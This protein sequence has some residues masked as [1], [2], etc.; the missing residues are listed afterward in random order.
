MFLLSVINFSLPIKGALIKQVHLQKETFNFEQFKLP[1]SE[2]VL[3]QSKK[4]THC[5]PVFILVISQKPITVGDLKYNHLKSGLLKVRFQMVR[6]SNGRALAKAIAIVP[7]IRKPDHSKSR[8]YC[9]D[10]KWFLTKWRPFVRI[11]NGWA[12]GYQIPF[13]IW[14]IFHPTS[15]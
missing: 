9:P 4:L 15:N 2:A 11:S 14:T 7:T 6:F 5:K 13:K 12:S 1:R 8:H 10:F 3:E